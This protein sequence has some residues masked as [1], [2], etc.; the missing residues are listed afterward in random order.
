MKS[1]FRDSAFSSDITPKKTIWTST[2]IIS[3]VCMLASGTMNT[4]GF[5]VQ[6]STYGFNHGV[7]QTSFMFLGEFMNLFLLNIM[8]ISQ[9]KRNRSFREMKKHAIE[10]NLSF[11]FSRLLIGLPSLLDSI[12]SALQIVAILLMPASINQMLSGGTIITT[13]LIR[14]LIMK[15]PIFSH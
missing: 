13:T 12:G 10:N 11:K 2:V 1:S 15:K 9:T 3:T 5:K 4:I 14:W 8:M 7:V 6:G